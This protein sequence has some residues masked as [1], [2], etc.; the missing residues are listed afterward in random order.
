MTRKFEL[1][2]CIV[3]PTGNTIEEILAISR[4]NDFTKWGIPGGKQDPG[5]SNAVCACREIGEELGI[6]LAPEDLIPLYSGACYGADGRDFWVTTYLLNDIFSGMV[7]SPEEGLWVKPMEIITLC[8]E[9]LSP[10]AYYNQNV[11]AA[12][13]RL[14]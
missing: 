12:W 7:E 6:F 4:R 14:R 10:F 8:S 1:A 11:V 13:R 3:I 5:E 2:A 9:T